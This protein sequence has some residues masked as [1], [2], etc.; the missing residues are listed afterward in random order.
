MGICGEADR[1]KKN[2]DN[3][4][5]SINY[6]TSTKTETSLQ[7]KPQISP[8]S[9]VQGNKKPSLNKKAPIIST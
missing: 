4:N 9:S 7:Y 5:F 1:R 8:Y 3:K 6:P 2:L